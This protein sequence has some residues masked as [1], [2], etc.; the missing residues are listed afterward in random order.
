MRAAWYALGIFEEQDAWLLQV[1]FKCCADEHW[2]AVNSVE[3][4]NR[5]PEAILVPSCVRNVT[6]AFDPDSMGA[7]AP[8]TRFA[9]PHDATID[10]ITAML[11]RRVVIDLTAVADVLISGLLGLSPAAAYCFLAR[12]GEFTYC[13]L[14]PRSF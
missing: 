14:S 6:V 5:C 7:V 11:T 13:C 10:E 12:F 8:C 2:V 1:S 4:L 3:Q 9:V